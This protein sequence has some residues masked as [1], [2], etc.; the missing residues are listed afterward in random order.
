MFIVPCTLVKGLRSN[1]SNPCMETK[2]VK[3]CILGNLL[4]HPE[5]G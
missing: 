1:V 2:P 3:L 5:Q 4:T